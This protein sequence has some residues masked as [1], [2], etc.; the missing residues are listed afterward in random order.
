MKVQELVEFV[1][2]SKNKLLKQTQLEEVVAKHIETKKYLP[3]KQK[4]ELVE[5]IVNEC[6]LYEDGV[7]KFDDID[8]YICFTMKVIAAYTNLE[9]SDDIEDDYDVLC[10]AGVLDMVIN[11]FKKEYD[12]VNILLQMKCDYVLSS[13]SLEAQV[14]KLF[15]GV[16]EKLDIITQAL[17]NKV[18]GFDI[19]NLPISGDDLSKLMQ[20]LNMQQ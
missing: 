3:I 2:N 4:K 8:K 19:N 16:L 18:E 7:Y 10:E 13:N 12:E 20:L 15:D 17:A 11:T 6:I 14:G 5:S 9:I 1:S